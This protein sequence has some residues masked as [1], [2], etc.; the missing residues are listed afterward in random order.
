MS[1]AEK[2]LSQASGAAQSRRR[3]VLVAASAALLVACLVASYLTQ[4]A[5]ANLPFLKARAGLV[6]QQPWQT[7]S[8]LANLAVSSEEKRDAREAERL[9]D[10]EVDQAFAM[11]LR[12][13]AMETTVL[14]GPAL[15][16]QK[17]INALADRVK[18][19]QAAV[20]SLN[21]Q[22]AKH[23][24]AAAGSFQNDL[25]VAKAQLQLDTDEMNDASTKLAYAS[26]DRRIRIQRELAAHEASMQKYDS[27]A[28]N[29]GETAVISEKRHRTLYSRIGAWL[30]QRSR[31]SSL[32]QA[33]TQT[34]REIASLTTQ[35]EELEAELDA[36]TARIKATAAP[37]DANSAAVSSYTDDRLASMAHAHNLAQILSILEDRLDTSKQLTTVYARWIAQVNL[38]H[39][40]VL[41]LILQSMAE[42]AALLLV[43][44]LLWL[45]VQVLLDRM[46]GTSRAD[47]R[48]LHTLRMVLSLAIQV[49]T[50]AVVLLMVFGAPDGMPTILGLCV[51]GLTVVFQ[52]FILAFF[53][54][55]V[56]MGRNGIRVGD[57][58][59][60][61]SVDGEVVEVGLFRTTMLETGNGHP[62]GRR[63]RFLNS[64]AVTGQFFNFSTTGQWTWDEI[65]VNVPTGEGT[66]KIIEAIHK[67]VESQTEADVKLAEKEWQGATNRQA[68]GHFSAAPTVN[69]RPATSGIDI[70]VRYVTRAGDRFEMRNKLYQ[71]VI[72]I[73]Q[74]PIGADKVAGADNLA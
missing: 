9:A 72:D 64:F 23:G 70:L 46:A 31:T 33:Q 71:S 58:V 52:N 48:S 4:G 13:A 41:H 36:A 34:N 27:Q 43:A 53:G 19:D 63:V 74:P 18:Q 5:M 50:L 1:G 24:G 26:G 32:Q 66:Y 38:Q 2:D 61:N 62:T 47:R 73:L 17:E 65:S 69:M 20:N 25:A 59:E 39:R 11:A 10:H 21:A 55:F 29:P 30:D 3:L 40:I 67:A 12:Q 28:N 22:A 16:I 60:I 51:A 14:T 56:L 7:A 54:W 49:V 42:I 57:W 6:D 68:L 45:M 37:S 35:H 8:A 15:D 44:V